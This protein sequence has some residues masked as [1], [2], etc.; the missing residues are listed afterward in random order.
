MVEATHIRLK[1]RQKMLKSFKDSSI[2]FTAVRN[3]TTYAGDNIHVKKKHYFIYA[4]Q[5]GYG[6]TTFSSAL[7]TS[8]NA[9]AVNDLNNFIGVRENAQ[10]LIFDYFS[11]NSKITIDDLYRLT[12]G[13]ASHF[14]GN[15]KTFGRSFIPRADAQVIILSNNHLFDC[16]GKYN[17]N[18]KRRTVN[19]FT[20]KKLLDRFH[21][22]K[23]DDE[24]Q[25]E[26][27]DAILSIDV[28]DIHAI[29]YPFDV[30][31]DQNGQPIEIDGNVTPYSLVY[32][33]D[34][35]KNESF[36]SMKKSILL[37]LGK[38]TIFQTD[39][40]KTHKAS[41]YRFY[42]LCVDDMLKR[43]IDY[44]GRLNEFLECDSNFDILD[45]FLK[46]KKNFPS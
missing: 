44:Q 31:F 10:F 23:L 5:S 26:I 3:V 11:H 38:S 12:C 45:Y 8:L 41:A 43:Y 40:P 22:I 29:C 19:Y 21:I 35:R 7:K 34:T 46:H 14:I 36:S 18:T 24:Y 13:N 20:A 25:S 37:L 32:K 33:F 9:C 28:C 6:K 4:N 2:A 39:I 42:S 1:K 30:K 27:E 16:I 15:K 17:Q